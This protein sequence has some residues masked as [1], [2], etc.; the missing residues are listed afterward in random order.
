MV[1]GMDT[2]WLAVL[3]L[4]AFA[5]P[6][7]LAATPTRWAYRHWTPGG[8]RTTL[9]GITFDT[10]IHCGNGHNFVKVA[11]AHYRFRARIDHAPYTWRFCVKLH[12]PRAVGRTITLEV[13]DFD[14]GGRN[15][16]QERATVASTDG[17]HWQP[18]GTRN[19]S[20]VPWTPTGHAA[21]DARYG[22]RGHIPYGVQ[23]RLKLTAHTLWL[24]SP[25]PY[26]LDRRDTVLAELATA[27]PTLVHTTTI[28]HSAHSKAHGHPL[29]MT[30]ITAPGDATTR[31]AIFLIAGEHCSE[32]AGIHACEGW[33]REVL[34]H[35]DWLRQFAFY[36]VPIVNVD[37][38]FY[39]ATYYNLAPSLAKGIGQNISMN[40]AD[41]TL[42]EVKALWTQL[43]RLRPVFFAS[44]HNGRHRR[45]MEAFGP[46]GTGTDALLAA[47]RRELGHPFQGIRSHGP[48]T[49]AYGVLDQ[50]GI[51]HLAY[52]IETL[53]LC[54]QKG[55]DT[56]QASY[57]ATG[58]QLARGT[59]AALRAMPPEAKR[60]E[61]EGTRGEGRGTRRKATP[62]AAC[63]SPTLQLTG[64]AFTAQLPW[65][66]HGLPFSKPR[67]HDIYSFE[68]N[69][70][71]LPPADYT[72]ALVPKANR[73][74]LAVSLDGQ[75]FQ[76]M[77]VRDGRV[78]LPAVGVH[79]RMLSLYVRAANVQGTSPLQ[80]ALVYPS[81]TTFAEAK[82]AAQPFRLY[83]RNIR[84]AERDILKP[85]NWAE[86]HRLLG[87]KGFGKKQLRAMF[88]DIVAWCRRRQVLDPHD[89][90]YGAIYSEEDKYDF[91][92][93]AAAAVCFAY[94]WR[95]TGDADA[96]HRA[97][98]ARGYC[99]RGQHMANPRNKARYGGFCHMVHGAWGKGMQRL[100]RRLGPTVGVETA[101]IA[102]LLVKTYELGLEPTANDVDHLRAA[103]TWMMNNEFTPGVFRHHEGATHDC[104][105]SN[106][107]G[108]VALARA[109]EALDTLGHNPPA[110]WLDAAR[111]G[112]AHW[113]EG[114]EAIGCWPY[115][116]AT[117]GRGQAFR[118]QNLP[119]QGMGFY[120]FAVAA[121]TPAFRDLP[122][123]KQAMARAARWWLCM[124]RIDRTGPMPTI[125]LD[126]RRAAGQLK[127]SAFTWCRFMAAASLMRIAE[128]TH[129]PEPWR[130][131]ALRYIEHVHTKLWNTTDPTTAPVRRATRDDMTL[132][133]WI[134][135]AEWD[136]V[137]LREIEERLP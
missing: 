7:A 92:D 45:T 60:P 44:L 54:R 75:A 119:D 50:A 89:R 38:V 102:N 61:P 82:A 25:T 33:M 70:L 36:F 114:Q 22:D 10:T 11:D 5:C 35:P 133:S 125:D 108:A 49:R 66:Y 98:L 85:E 34:A 81:G 58:R 1:W 83:R 135:A 110:E 51:T 93:A 6:V 8:E 23:Y 13:A 124:S 20:I 105:N 3:V 74:K 121:D 107:L 111:R 57:L 112:M 76:N 9:D 87:R 32:T 27:H 136:G 88:D 64:A 78:E 94:A 15:L 40:W 73:R 80:S 12:C 106:A 62:Q 31:E 71:P 21:A 96:R 53:L 137:L 28:G 130:Q 56:F 132:C 103:A 39:G 115:T 122:G 127:F 43:T 77:P 126:D 24:A 91:R 2:G 19:I 95:D 59:V 47:W 86:F 16:W 113:L 68:A 101:I 29:R 65:F 90:H 55:F 14:H 120:H 69:A 30:R 79:N 100:G 131:L 41:R 134:Q 118:E 63:P 4:A 99:Y 42:P 46:P 37:G 104:Q 128:S 72:V 67:A 17:E 84:T 18:L 117:I 52:T 109:H 97:L 129:E 48:A 116:F 26:T 123:V